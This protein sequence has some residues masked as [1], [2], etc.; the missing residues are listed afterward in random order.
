MIKIYVCVT[1]DLFHY[2]HL[3]F[4]KKA[5]EF[6]D[7][8]I[9]GVHS[10]EDVAAFKWPPVLNLD[11]RVAVIECCSLVNEVIPNAPPETNAIF[12]Q[13][14]QIDLVVASKA[15]SRKALKKYYKDP[16]KM[17]ILKLVDYEE[18][19]STSY[20]VERCA[21]LFKKRKKLKKKL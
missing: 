9:V 6:G 13:K 10:D 8:L 12:I 14:H 4:F 5:R 19:I 1:G 18:C 16:Q 3:S 7:Y 15:Y 20:I 11:Q 17:N 21:Q 2:G